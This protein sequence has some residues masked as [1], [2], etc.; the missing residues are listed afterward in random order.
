L[1]VW[2]RSEIKNEGDK[3]E[4]IQNIKVVKRES[5]NKV[6]WLLVVL[7]VLD[8]MWLGYNGF[9]EATKMKKIQVMTYSEKQDIICIQKMKME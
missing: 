6:D 8:N 2:G 1:E 5:R 4:V 3:V 7:V 9:K